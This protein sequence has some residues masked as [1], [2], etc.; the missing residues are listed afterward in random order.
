M[1]NFI[2]CVNLEVSESSAKAVK[3]Q[4][5]S[6]GWT[7]H[8]EIRKESFYL[9]NAFPGHINGFSSFDKNNISVFVYGELYPD[10][11]AGI[12]CGEAVYQSYIKS[13]YKD[14]C[15][16]CGNYLILILDTEKNKL[17]I[18]NDAMGFS[19]VFYSSTSRGFIFSN[20]IKPMFLLGNINNEIDQRA[21]S[22]YIQ[23]GY[24]LEDKT[25]F[26]SIKRLMPGSVIEYSNNTLNLYK[27][28]GLNFSD[29]N[30]HLPLV[31]VADQMYEILLKGYK[32]RIN[33]KKTLIPLSGGLDSRLNVGFY[34]RISRGSFEVLTYGLVYHADYYA[35]RKVSKTLG[36]NHILV[37]FQRN[38]ISK[39][40]MDFSSL[41]EGWADIACAQIF[42]VVDHAKNNYDSIITG[43]IGGTLTGVNL[44][45]YPLEAKTSDECF[46]RYIKKQVDPDSA[47]LNELFVVPSKGE[48]TESTFKASKDCFSNSESAEYNFQ[49]MIYID[50][51]Q[52]QRCLISSQ[53]V[54]FNH[55]ARAISPFFEKDF[56]DLVTSVSSAALEGQ[57]AYRLMFCRHF[58]ELSQIIHANDERPVSQDKKAVLN[59]F[60]YLTRKAYALLVLRVFSRINKAKI[61]SCPTS[62]WDIMSYPDYKFIASELGNMVKSKT[63]LDGIFSKACISRI[64][65][66]YIASKGIKYRVIARR[67]LG[68][69]Y[70]FRRGTNERNFRYLQEAAAKL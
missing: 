59:S 61:S 13:S 17:T 55:Y 25:L 9:H 40:G 51:M 34:N 63:L 12:S 7:A 30:W 21:A 47:C 42:P 19:P 66:E 43:T 36:I 27:I 38:Y 14:L 5:H 50:H 28:N 56:I 6:F 52:R 26:E 57:A 69:F 1:S 11:E 24:I 23:L 45:N 68:L 16:F 53:E 54:I 8:Q 29:K 44:D 39:Y 4:M 62:M 2:G 70:Y 35:A 37:P 31:Q 15:S 65:S 20:R 32:K 67:L 18:A 49:K 22:D 48:A 10:A 33:N 64:K 58:K 46:L 3:E 41:I 60:K